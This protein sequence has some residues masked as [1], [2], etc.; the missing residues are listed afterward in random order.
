MDQVH[1]F[2]PD[3]DAVHVIVETP[4]GTRN[5]LTYDEHYGLFRLGGVLPAGAVFP[6]D[7]GF[8]PSTLGDDGDPLDVLV[9]LDE[10]VSVG[11]LVLC[12]LIGVVEA[13]QTEEGETMRN[14]RLIAVAVNSHTHRDVERLED[15]TSSAV[16]EIEHVFASYNDFKD[17]QFRR[18]ARSSPARAR[19]LVEEGVRRREGRD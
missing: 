12:R 7:F 16:D 11:C 8:V 5:K 10:P 6:Y 3:S 19:Q 15:L 18:L 2:D 1:A 17:K 13:E 14:D 4:K 9:L